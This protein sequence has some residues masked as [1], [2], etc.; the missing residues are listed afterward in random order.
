MHA[1]FKR[2]V[3]RKVAPSEGLFSLRLP[4]FESYEPGILN[5]LP[6]CCSPLR[7]HNARRNPCRSCTLATPQ[8]GREPSLLRRFAEI[9]RNSPAI[10][11]DFDPNGFP[12]SSPTTPATQS[13]SPMCRNRLPNG[14]NWTS[15]RRPRFSLQGRVRVHEYSDGSIDRPATDPQQ[16]HN[17]PIRLSVPSAQ[18]TCRPD[19]R[20]AKNIQW[21]PS[22]R[23]AVSEAIAKRVGRESEDAVAR[24]RTRQGADRV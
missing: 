5:G 10:R 16:C 6:P 23:A 18:M 19:D 17:R 2:Q 12:S 14:V 7:P 24:T 11:A 21:C 20:C 3:E 9:G 1:P 22:M 15:R 8:L 4:K 13:V